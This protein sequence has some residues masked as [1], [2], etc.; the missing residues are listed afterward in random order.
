MKPL[1]LLSLATPFFSL[2]FVPTARAADPAPAPPAPAK[3]DAP[4]P[5]PAAPLVI[6]SSTHGEAFINDFSSSQGKFAPYAVPNGL[7]SGARME[8][9][10]G[11]LKI[12]NTHAGSFGVT[13][14][15]PSFDALKFSHLSFDY[16]M[17]PSVKVNIFLRVNG[18]YH[19]I[20]FSGPDRVRA[21]SIKLGTIADVQTDDAW[22]RADLPLRDWLQTLYPTADKFTIDDIIIGNWDNEGYL[23]AG[24]GGNPVGATYFLDNFSLSGPRS[25]AG[26][27]KFDLKS[28]GDAKLTYALDDGEYQPVSGQTLS[29]KTSDGPHL[30]SVLRTPPTGEAFSRDLSV[31]DDG[32][33]AAGGR[34]EFWM[35]IRCTFRLRVLPHSI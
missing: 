11:A 33:G 6:S 31:R 7:P 30:L 9:D 5:M 3:A 16:R 4:A 22:H 26:E 13:T 27:A 15:L 8:L 35:A 32:S 10:G 24:F 17:Q 19:G 18:K 29:L 34:A 2:A 1:V 21:G 14:G 20:I 12:V 25:P 28:S 23:V